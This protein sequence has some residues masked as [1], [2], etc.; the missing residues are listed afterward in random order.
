M[1]KDF[2]NRNNE[3][4]NIPKINKK[5]ERNDESLI[6]IVGMF[7][8]IAS[9]ASLGMY[10]FGSLF[11]D[12]SILHFLWFF[13][14]L[15]ITLLVALFSLIHSLIKKASKYNNRNFWY[16]MNIKDENTLKYFEIEFRGDL[17]TYRVNEDMFLTKEIGDHLT[18][19]EFEQLTK[20]Y[21]I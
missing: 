3:E 12:G 14:G 8:V 10:G 9:L 21:L 15:P 19:D 1:I 20:F 18:Q 4:Y 7:L 17:N 11:A 5:L 13:I 2:L 6:S 16:L